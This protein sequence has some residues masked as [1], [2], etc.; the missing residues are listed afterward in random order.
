MNRTFQ[1]NECNLYVLNGPLT[2]YRNKRRIDK[3]RI[4]LTETA[5]ITRTNIR[6]NKTKH[7]NK[8]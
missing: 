4:K 3:T 7:Q 8:V 6:T 5:L 1:V 2:E